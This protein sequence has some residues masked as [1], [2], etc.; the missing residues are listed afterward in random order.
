MNYQ[1][2]DLLPLKE[3]WLN[4]FIKE[5]WE[6]FSVVAYG[7]ELEPLLFFFLLLLRLLFCDLPLYLL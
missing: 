3:L 4:V 7:Y 6:Y 1:L 2:I 5:V